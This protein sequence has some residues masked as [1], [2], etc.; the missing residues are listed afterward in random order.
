[1]RPAQP[2][3]ESRPALSCE[4][5]PSSD[6][7]MPHRQSC[8][9]RLRKLTEKFVACIARR[10][11]FLAD[12]S[13]FFKVREI[14]GI[15]LDTR[16]LVAVALTVDLRPSISVSSPSK[17]KARRPIQCRSA[18]KPPLGGELVRTL[19]EF[20]RR[21][22]ANTIGTCLSSQASIYSCLQAWKKASLST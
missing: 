7:P 15:P 22:A 17:S 13:V 4:G 14:E 3:T 11:L 2:S 10:L 18:I 9:S 20:P 1:M 21:A 12:H 8:A 6:I 16:T 5:T 19:K